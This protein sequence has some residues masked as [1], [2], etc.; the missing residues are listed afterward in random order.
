MRSWIEILV[1]YGGVIIIY[2]AWCFFW[3]VFADV[4]DKKAP[5]DPYHP[6]TKE[7]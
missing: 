7:H 4:L 3:K 6:R 5:R 1:L 2:T